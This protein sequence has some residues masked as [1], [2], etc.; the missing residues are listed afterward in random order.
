MDNAASGVGLPI[1]VTCWPLIDLDFESNIFI[2]EANRI[3]VSDNS[4]SAG[5]RSYR[6]LVIDC[7]KYR[8]P[9]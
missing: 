7:P 1:K 4:A 5:K 6:I 3:L 2:L 9:K 8:K